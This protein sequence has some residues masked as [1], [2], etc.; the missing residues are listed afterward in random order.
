MYEFRLEY[1]SAE[2]EG[3][4]LRDRAWNLLQRHVDGLFVQPDVR[5]VRPAA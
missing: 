5:F 2:V 1:D 3:D 4:N